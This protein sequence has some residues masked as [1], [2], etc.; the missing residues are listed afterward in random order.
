MMLLGDVQGTTL[1]IIFPVDPNAEY[2]LPPPFAIC[3]DTIVR[4]PFFISTLLPTEPLAAT[5]SF[6]HVMDSAYHSDFFIH[7]QII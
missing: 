4:H 6:P 3:C 1:I 5:R 7:I 2:P